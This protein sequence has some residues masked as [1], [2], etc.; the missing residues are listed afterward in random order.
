MKLKTTNLGQ[1]RQNSRRNTRCNFSFA[2]LSEKDGQIDGLYNWLK[3]PPIVLGNQLEVAMLFIAPIL[4][5][6]SVYLWVTVWPWYF[7]FLLFL[8]LF[9]GYAEICF[10]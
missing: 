3:Q 2:D 8:G 4:C 10:V 1:G 7:A 6:S 9:G 5:I